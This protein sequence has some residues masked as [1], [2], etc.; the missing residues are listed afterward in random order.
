MGKLDALLE[1]CRTCHACRLGET[2]TNLVFGTGNENARLMFV[3]EGP[4]AQEDLQGIPYL[5]IR[6]RCPDTS[7]NSTL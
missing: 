4:G 2:R 3:G 5:F 7:P 1:T 6:N